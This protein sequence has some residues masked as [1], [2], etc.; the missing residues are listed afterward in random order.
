MLKKGTVYIYD[1]KRS[2][3]NNPQKPNI[4]FNLNVTK[5]ERSGHYLTL[6]DPCAKLRLWSLSEE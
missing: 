1:S 5:I 6:S 4:F 2:C 3:L